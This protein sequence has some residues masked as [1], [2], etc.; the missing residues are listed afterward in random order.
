MHSLKTRAGAAAQRSARLIR[1]RLQFTRPPNIGV[2]LGTGWGD[3][4]GLA[5]ER[6]LPLVQALEARRSPVFAE[7]IPG[8][9]RT[10]CY[11]SVGEGAARKTV[12]ALRG[13]LHLNEGPSEQLLPLVR[14]QAEMLLA[15]GIRR[16]LF[17]AAVGSLTPEAPVGSVVVPDGF[18]TL[19]APD[20]PLFGGE[21]CSPEDAL[22]PKLQAIALERAEL[23]G[24]KTVAGAHAM[25]R[26]PFFE[27]R[28]YDKKLLAQG[29]ALADVVGTK[30]GGAHHH[31]G[32]ED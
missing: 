27:G 23:H 8:H 18:M 31:G 10:V 25:V 26:G 13:R 1:R 24:L 16:F 29:F 20:M 7:T 30:R 22:D 11:G 15:L 14:R 2:I 17:T 12:L 32:A 3:T 9:A 21:F 5:K 28:R 6:S 4:L 19:L